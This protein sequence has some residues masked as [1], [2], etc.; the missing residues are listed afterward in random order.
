MVDGLGTTHYN[1][2]A[3]G[4]PGALKLESTD[5]PYQNDTVSYQ[6]DEL[7]RISERT[8]DVATES[9]SYDALNRLVSHN[10]PLGDFN[11]SY[12][13]QTSQLTR[14]ALNNG[15]VGTAWEYDSNLHDRH[16]LAIQSIGAARGFNYQTN[17]ENNIT[18]ISEV[19]PPNPPWSARNWNYSYDS[20][21]R[22][23]SAQPTSGNAYNYTYDAVD[24]ITGQN[25]TQFSNNE[26]NQITSARSQGS[27]TGT[28]S[29]DGNGNILQDNTS[30]ALFK[31]LWDAENRLVQV[32][33]PS[34]NTVQFRY[35]GLG[36]RLAIVSASVENRYLWCGESICQSRNA[37]DVV[38]WRYYQEGETRPLASLLLY[39]S[40]DQ[41]GSVRD[42]LSVT[43]GSR[44]ASLD[45][46]PYGN[47]I[48]ASGS[49]TPDFQYAGMFHETSSGYY[50]TNYRAYNPGNGRWLNRDPIGEQ[51]GI[52]LYA[53]VNS[54][55]IS[56]LDLLGLQTS[57][58]CSKQSNQDL[59]NQV[60]G[61]LGDQIG[62]LTPPKIVDYGT[63]IGNELGI[64]SYLLSLSQFEDDPLNSKAQMDLLLNT[65]SAIVTVLEVP[66]AVDI[67]GVIGF[68][69]ALW[70]V[71]SDYSVQRVNSEI[72]FYKNNISP[73]AYPYFAAPFTGAIF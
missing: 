70:D 39:Y 57:D 4:Q 17:P 59:K 11:L 71:E 27:T 54:N 56:N 66:I 18:Q 15:M 65:A 53:Y 49:I 24:N 37:S 64:V 28:A 13:G 3:L 61:L 20:K 55:P 48:Q 58:S 44:L 51:G 34:G 72:W 29:Y 68:G 46:D 23:E 10:S 12:L 41:I 7:G 9:F 69:E 22:L 50:L 63:R 8:I 1:Y 52:N 26:L 25:A 31:Y 33:Q 36:Q 6:Y 5:G 32:T 67:F 42:V 2:Q 38:T 19:A 62:L 47:T 30:G 35:N 60:F 43:N 73:F 40:R 16:L 45:Y 21:N 14:Q